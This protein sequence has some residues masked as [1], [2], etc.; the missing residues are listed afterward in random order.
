MANGA[1]RPIH[2]VHSQGGNTKRQHANQH[3]NNQYCLSWKMYIVSMVLNLFITLF[4]YMYIVF[5]LLRQQ[6]SFVLAD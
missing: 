6:M 4:T 3:R 1:A 2:P 5:V